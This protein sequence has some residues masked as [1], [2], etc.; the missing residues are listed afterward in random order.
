MGTGQLKLLEVTQNDA[1]KKVVIG[2]A[3]EVGAFAA[4]E[5]AATSQRNAIGAAAPAA[6]EPEP[7]N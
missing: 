2:T 1:I 3:D 6:G 7:E 4:N 5:L